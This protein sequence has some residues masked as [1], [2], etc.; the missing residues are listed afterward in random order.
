MKKK[1]LLFT[2]IPLLL[3]GPVSCTQNEGSGKVFLHFGK[4]HETKPER[5]DEITYDEISTLVEGDFKQSFAFVLSNEGCTCWKSF[6]P[7]LAEFNYKYN[8][9]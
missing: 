5:V 2:L 4:V 8:L 7:I 1:L 3:L 6:E 9:L